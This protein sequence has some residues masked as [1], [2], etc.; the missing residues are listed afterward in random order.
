MTYKFDF[1][2]HRKAFFLIV[3]ITSLIAIGSLSIQGLN[4]G[5]DFVS[6]TRLD[7][8]FDKPVDL[9]KSRQVIEKMGYKDPNLRVG[10]DQKDVLIFRLD[11][12]IDKPAVDQI[13]DQMDQAFQTKVVV[14]EQTVDP[15]IG[16]ELAKNAMYALL[17]ASLFIIIYITFRFEY[18]FAI[19]AI[20]ALLYDALFTVGMFSLLQ[21][22]VDL[23]FIA[24]ILTI[25]GYSVNDTIVIFD[26][27]RENL[28][29][30]NPKNFDDLSQLVNVSINQTLTRS[31]NTVLTVVF[32]AAALYILG[33]ESI[34]NFSFALLI[35]L[36]SG[37]YSSIFIASQ[38]WVSW[39]WHSMKRDKGKEPITAE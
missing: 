25:V 10:G 17:L 20:L 36:A 3:I 24:A 28:N 31:I 34:S 13:R 26:R 35:G 22:E 39:K 4:L 33:G 9:E 6:G 7:V 21:I 19:A 11:Q 1:V 32:A 18:R 16:R 15:I 14:Q 37:A 29:L 5:I 2:K 27:I 23:V 8:T 38:I 12:K 30:H